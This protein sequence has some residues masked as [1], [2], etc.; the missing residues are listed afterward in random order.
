V[1]YAFRELAPSNWFWQLRILFVARFQ[2][3]DWD[4]SFLED[5]A[6]SLAYVENKKYIRRKNNN[7]KIEWQKKNISTMWVEE[8][9]CFHP[10]KFVIYTADLLFCCHLLIY[11]TS[12]RTQFFYYSTLVN[13][14]QCSTFKPNWWDDIPRARGQQA[15]HPII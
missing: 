2:A 9:R 10:R 8:F 7:N 15:G 4:E 1:V 3:Y 13:A 11:Y 6:C 5:A 12:L 14:K